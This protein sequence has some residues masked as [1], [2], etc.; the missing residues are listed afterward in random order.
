MLVLLL[1][2]PPSSSFSLTNLRGGD[3]HTAERTVSLINGVGVTFA[4]IAASLPGGPLCARL[5]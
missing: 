4:G 5:P 3:F 2:A 1:F